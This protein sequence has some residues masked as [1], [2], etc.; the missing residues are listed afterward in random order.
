MMP[1]EKRYETTRKELFAIVTGLK[2]FCQY[3]LGRH[4]I[5]RTDHAALS[6]LRRTAKPM[7]QLARWLTYIEQFDY[8][9]LHRPGV[10]HGN[11]DA[12]SR[13]PP[14]IELDEQGLDEDEELLARKITDDS[15]PDQGGM[16]ERQ[17]Q[18]PELGTFVRLRKTQQDPPEP[19]EV[20]VES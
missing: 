14:T 8:E 5:I 17:Q 3:L 19:E 20:Q 2:H 4:I 12:L 9:V 13:R 6:W 10:R 7:P 11:T 18:D 1:T 16:V 15:I